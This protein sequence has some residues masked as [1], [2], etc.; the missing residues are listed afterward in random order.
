MYFWIA[1]VSL[2]WSSSGVSPPVSSMPYGKDIV[3]QGGAERQ[4]ENDENGDERRYRKGGEQARVMHVLDAMAAARWARAAEPANDQCHRSQGACSNG[5]RIARYPFG[6][7]RSCK[8][9]GEPVGNSA[10]AVYEQRARSRFALTK[11]TRTFDEVDDIARVLLLP[12]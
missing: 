10:H 12:T 4:S 1:S 3:G 6:R 2:A 8:P 5:S 7:W 9:G 11:G